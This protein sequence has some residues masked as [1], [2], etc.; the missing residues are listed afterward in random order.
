M[1][2]LIQLTATKGSKTISK[3]VYGNL[4]QKNVLF[5]RLMDRFSV[6]INE[7]YLWKL[8]EVKLNK[9]INL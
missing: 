1:K 3:E 6:P 9:E 5:E 2:G 4:A 8:T 7:R